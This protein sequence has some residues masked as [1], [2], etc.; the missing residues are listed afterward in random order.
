MKIELTAYELSRIYDAL[1][2]ADSER[3][4]NILKP[5]IHKIEDAL[6]GEAAI[7]Q[8]KGESK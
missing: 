7:A 8:A 5:I 6:D 4:D 1:C 2:F 3:E